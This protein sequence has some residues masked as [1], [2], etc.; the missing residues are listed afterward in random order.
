[1]NVKNVTR[2][3]KKRS[4]KLKENICKVVGHVR[5]RIGFRCKRCRVDLPIVGY[6]MI[7]MIIHNTKGITK[8]H[9][10]GE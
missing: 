4:Q 5:S 8:M 10:K 3:A 9:F 2:Q 7:G 1:M 6:E